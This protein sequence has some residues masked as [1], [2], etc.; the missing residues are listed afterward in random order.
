M[1]L[2][3]QAAN[4]TMTLF[5]ILDMNTVLLDSNGAILLLHERDGL[6]DMLLNGQGQD[7]R[8]LCAETLQSPD[9]CCLYTNAWGLS[10]VSALYRNEGEPD[11]I[12]CIGPFLKQIPDLHPIDSRLQGNASQFAQLQDYYRHLKLI[13]SAKIQSI[14]SI[15][16]QADSIRHAQLRYVEAADEDATGSRTKDT[17]HP[18]NLLL[19]QAG[20]N[21]AELIELRYKLENEMMHAVQKGD[22]QQVRERSKYAKN[23][24]DF[25]ERLPNQP[26]R[27]FR[28]MLIVLNTLLRVAARNGN[29]PPYYIHRLSEKFSKQIERSDNI[30]TLAALSATMHEAYCDLVKERSVGGY[31]PLVQQA[32]QYLGV[33]YRKPLDL[34]WLAAR[35]HV[36]P[37]H[38]SRQFKKETKLTLTDYLN[39]QRVTE[40]KHALQ[41][42]RASIDWIAGYVGFE[43]AGYFARVFK[44]LEGMTPREYRER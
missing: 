12:V 42:E 20:G 14:A 22:K 9:S 25:S 41:K 39:K 27:A 35:C 23:L 11:R 17:A 8:R 4:T 29:V 24:Y 38:L 13:S 21:N 32:M 6:P 10:Y 43:D 31:S 16:K 19:S 3:L 1:T 7:F 28:N 33:H 37:S 2:P 30:G 40:A 44:R 15:L 36:H 26:I 34:K 18:A 5:H